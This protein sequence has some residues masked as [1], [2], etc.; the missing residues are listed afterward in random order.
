[1]TTFKLLYALFWYMYIKEVTFIIRCCYISILERNHESFLWF[2]MCL[3]IKET[4]WSIITWVLR[5]LFST[6]DLEWNPPK[7]SAIRLSLEQFTHGCKG[8]FFKQLLSLFIRPCNRPISWYGVPFQGFGHTKYFFLCLCD[9][10]KSF[11]KKCHRCP[12]LLSLFYK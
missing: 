1:M 2:R 7:E 9:K 4:T 8:R 10:I 5:V 11:W 12:S 6:S 3:T